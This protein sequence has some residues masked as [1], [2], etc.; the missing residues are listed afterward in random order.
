MTLD[1]QSTKQ[2]VTLRNALVMG[3]V[4]SAALAGFTFIG[5]KLAE[6]KMAQSQEPKPA[7]AQPMP[8]PTPAAVVNNELT[9]DMRD[10][11]VRA[12]D[13]FPTG[14]EIDNV[15][16]VK[17]GKN[18]VK[19]TGQLVNKSSEAVSIDPLHFKVFNMQNQVI[20]EFKVL[21]GFSM[22]S[23]ESRRIRETAKLGDIG[24]EIINRIQYAGAASGSTSQESTAADSHEADSYEETDSYEAP[25]SQPEATVTAAYTFNLPM[26]SCGDALG[27]GST[28]FPVFID[29]GDLDE[30]RSYYCNDARPTTRE[31]TGVPAV[32]VAS[33]SS[34]EKAAA[35]AQ[36]I[37][38]EVGQAT[39]R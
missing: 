24:D 8:S 7:V 39:Y 33:F 1:N 2:P 17:T 5:F 29:N 21:G 10:G 15:K 4:G 18:V 14:V 16:M 13:D 23:G 28:W 11:Q 35:F 32:Q 3:M 31:D 22:E 9:V 26:P 27:A 6:A 34:Y 36:A 38:G 30:I 19:I 20:G 25:I 12:L 37:D